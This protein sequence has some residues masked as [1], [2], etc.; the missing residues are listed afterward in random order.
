MSRAHIQGY[1]SNPAQFARMGDPWV[2]RREQ[3]EL[4]SAPVSKGQ[5]R[6]N[7]KARPFNPNYRDVER[8]ARPLT[9]EEE[10]ARKVR[11]NLALI[12]RLDRQARS[13]PVREVAGFKPKPPIVNLVK[14]A[15]NAELTLEQRRKR[16]AQR[17]EVEA[18]C[19]RADRLVECDRLRAVIAAAQARLEELAD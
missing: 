2:T 3:Q 16:E 13:Q 19:E 7:R 17:A 11:A 8:Q 18:R 6:A 14:P 9:A 4:G 1:D 10:Q 12:R 5:M 15:R